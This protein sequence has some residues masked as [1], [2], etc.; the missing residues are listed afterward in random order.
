MSS[1]GLQAGK[2]SAGVPFEDLTRLRSQQHVPI[3]YSQEISRRPLD[4]FVDHLHVGALADDCS[5]HLTPMIL[6]R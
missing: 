3:R 5:A 6:M 2:S 1:D 4:G